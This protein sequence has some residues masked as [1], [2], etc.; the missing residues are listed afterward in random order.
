MGDWILALAVRAN[1]LAGPVITLLYPL[2]ASIQAIES[3][4]KEDEQQ[5][6]TY[7]VLY[8]F[9]TLFEVA[10]APVLFWYTTYP[11]KFPSSSSSEVLQ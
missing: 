9:I 10:A 6:L 2:Y 5:W 11:Q 4:S 3:P 1:I 8:S 7:W